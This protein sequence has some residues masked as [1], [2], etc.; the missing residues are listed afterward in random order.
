MNESQIKAALVSRIEKSKCAATSAII[1]ELFVENFSRRADV[2]VA[3]GVLSAFEI[4]SERDSL[5]R[6][7][8]QVSVYCKYFEETTVVCAEKHLEVVSKVV[9][10]C[11]GVWKVCSDG[12]IDVVKRSVRVDQKIKANWLS[13]LPVCE[14]RC[15][16]RLNSLPTSGCRDVLVSNAEKIALRKIRSHVL[17][18]LKE[19]GSKIGVDSKRKLGA[20]SATTSF[21]ADNDERIRA[22]L[23]S[24]GVVGGAIPRRID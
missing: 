3:N 14:L 7:L 5:N 21:S 13:F 18:Y 22:Y 1:Q 24:V 11:V 2:V 12:R 10:E 4:K 6:L 19:R 23:N 8:G 20:R 9:P 15:F 16:L 17:G